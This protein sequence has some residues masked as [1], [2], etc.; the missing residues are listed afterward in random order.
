MK[1][2]LRDYQV[3]DLALMI[4]NPRLLNRS[5]PATGK[6]GSACA[7]IEYVWLYER[8][9]TIFVQPQSIIKKNLEELLAFTNFEPDDLFIWDPKK[10]GKLRRPPKVIL[11]TADSFTRNWLL[12]K[13]VTATG[14]K[15]F[16]GD[17]MHLY[18]STN[19]SK[20]TQF[21]YSA[22]RDIPRMLSLTG[23][24]VRGRMD[25]VYPI[26]QVIEPRYY[27]N[28]N[29]F[30]QE[31]AVIDDCGKIINWTNH[32]K[33]GQILLQHGINRTFAECY[34]AEKRLF[35]PV[36]VEMTTQ[37]AKVYE[38]FHN[39]AM[40]ELEG[41][42]VLS[43]TNEGVHALRCRQL[44]AHPESMG[45][46]GWKEETNAKDAWVLD[47]ICGQYNCGLLFSTLQPEQNRLVKVLRSKG[48][49]VGLI[50]GNVSLNKRAEIDRQFQAGELDWVVASPATAGVG[51]NW[52]RAEV[53]AF[54][55]TDYMDDNVV[56]AYRRA[57]RGIRDTALPIYL[58][59][60]PGT[61]EDRILEI[62]EQK[63]NL[64]F[65]VD[66]TRVPLKGLRL[67]K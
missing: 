9:C 48:A 44:L 43:A 7:Y 47:E 31:H 6:T 37:Q 53:V 16:V 8:G 51:F 2:T 35:I 1:K 57:I 50:N 26:I 39:L 36:P 59:Q 34:G 29:R 58:P 12:M 38:E 40:L 15:L 30:L 46:A 17:E 61:I 64:A 60:Y 10:V 45:I 21:W 33:L 24:A 18:Y 20:R 4:N 32:K 27:G 23:T 11:T 28:H 14:I 56:Q 41:D 49:R 42:D 54:V 19:D 3:Q 52:Q 22:M 63:S 25:S 67:P 13:S 62:I 65:R 55:S 66:A 5:E